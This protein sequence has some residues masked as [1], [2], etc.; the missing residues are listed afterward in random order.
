[1]GLGHELASVVHTF[2]VYKQRRPKMG[3]MLLGWPQ[4]RG[5]QQDEQT[6]CQADIFLA[7]SFWGV[8]RW[9]VLI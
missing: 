4:I 1:M 5:L 3:Q 6:V 8:V 9:L 2:V 7:R